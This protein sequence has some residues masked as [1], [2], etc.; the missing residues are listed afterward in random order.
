MHTTIPTKLRFLTLAPIYL[1]KQ[2][3]GSAVVMVN[4]FH[5]DENGKDFRPETRSQVVC[6]ADWHRLDIH[7]CTN[8][9]T[10][11]VQKN[12][13]YRTYLKPSQIRKEDVVIAV[14]GK[15]LESKNIQHQVHNASNTSE[16]AI[17]LTDLVTEII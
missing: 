9:F 4:G 5:V 2:K 16:C 10:V 13:F 11:K 12:D 14:N 6:A 8:V 15:S 3:D 7:T 17:K 1:S